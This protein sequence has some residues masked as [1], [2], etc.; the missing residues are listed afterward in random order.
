VHL[1]DRFTRDDVSA[2][3]W[4]PLAM[5][6]VVLCIATF[7]AQD[8]DR[9]RVHEDVLAQ[10]VS[11]VEE[12]L[13][14]A[15]A[16]IAGDRGL[17][18][19]GADTLGAELADRVLEEVPQVAAIRIW[20]ANG[21]LVFSTDARDQV[22]S[23]AAVNDEQIAEALRAPQQPLAFGSTVGLSGGDAPPRFVIY[24]A[25]AS[26]PD[27]AAQVEYDDDAVLAATDGRW[28]AWRLALAIAALGVLALAFLSI[29]EPVARSG[30]GVRFYPTSVPP[31]A[32]VIDRD[33]AAVLEQAGAH[34]RRRTQ[35]MQARMEALE[36]EKVRLE[37][38]LQRALSARAMEHAGP[39]SAIPRP[40]PAR[41]SP[42]EPDLVRV[43]EPT[44]ES[45]EALTPVEP[46]P[47][48]VAEVAPEPSAVAEPARVAEAEPE[49]IAEPEPEPEPV[50][51]PA[52]VGAEAAP[53]PVVRIPE[54]DAVEPPAPARRTRTRQ[55]VPDDTWA[56]APAARS[57]RSAPV[58]PAPVGGPDSDEDVLEVLHRLVEPVGSGA[59]SLDAASDM[60]ARLARTAAR[61]KPGS[62]SDERF[63]HPT[64]R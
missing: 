56:A 16:G 33:D 61:K 45:E 58:T 32:A 8:R 13:E 24:Q 44:M 3:V 11:I 26:V 37:G 55:P 50:N 12:V 40:A 51:E 53:E 31:G 47:D 17:D 22:G 48:L 4:W 10:G 2:K 42:A 49:P 29:R 18:A 60:R 64:D 15:Y 7:P 21:R 23:E 6:L 59:T 19:R 54:P 20:D 9:D 52:P 1:I 39:A 41:R 36:L 62:R 35:E 57:A 25:L 14:P 34:A 46:E 30:A 28:L 27:V 5:V 38:D 43:P 63:E